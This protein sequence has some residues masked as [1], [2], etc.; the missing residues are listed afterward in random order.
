[1]TRIKASILLIFILGLL[2][3]PVPANATGDGPYLVKDL[4]PGTDPFVVPTR[5]GFMYKGRYIFVSKDIT[6]TPV[7]WSTD[8]TE[9]G[10][11]MILKL[12]GPKV[13]TINLFG[14]IADRVI[15]QVISISDKTVYSATFD[16]QG[17]LTNPQVLDYSPYINLPINYILLTATDQLIYYLDGTYGPPIMMRT[18]GTTQGTFELVENSQS[19]IFLDSWAAELAPGGKP[20]GSVVISALQTVNN[21]LTRQFWLSDGSK[22]NT[23]IFFSAPSTSTVACPI[24]TVQ[25]F[26]GRI[27]FTACLNGGA[28]R[29]WVTDGTTAGTSPINGPDGT[30]ASAP[31]PGS[32]S[33]AATPNAYY[34]NGSAGGVGGLW[35]VPA[36]S[37]TAEK[38]RDFSLLRGSTSNV[39]GLADFNDLVL[40]NSEDGTGE[41]FWIS[42]GSAQGTHKLCA[43]CDYQPGA[44]RIAL[45]GLFF[46]SAGTPA[47]GYELWAT[48]GTENGTK[49]LADINPG[50]ASSNPRLFFSGGSILYFSAKEPIHGEELWAYRRG[51]WPEHL[52]LPLL[53]R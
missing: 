46:F 32:Y 34:F 44:A 43:S 30:P 42:D 41:T 15:F 7:F 35:K 31:D 9:Q 48:N 38:V 18:D 6:Q 49:L 47:E 25:P 16:A 36:G 4:V 8:G 17:N 21:V 27:I 20:S 39:I 5:E 28:R 3:P 51:Y 33:F 26:D 24:L 50:A 12:T 45:G 14:N 22:A 53:G 29:L 19:Y 1:M 37:S 2:Y 10:T 52:F 11:R 13:Y 23:H 40:F